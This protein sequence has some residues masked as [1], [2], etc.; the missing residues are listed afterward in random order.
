M[1][2]DNVTFSR[3]LDLSPR[4][5]WPLESDAHPLFGT[6]AKCFSK[7]TQGSC[8]LGCADVV[9]LLDAKFIRTDER[10]LDILTAEGMRVSSVTKALR[11]H[12]DR[13][14]VLSF[15]VENGPIF[16]SYLRFVALPHYCQL[17]LRH[18]AI[19]YIDGDWVDVP[20]PAVNTMWRLPL[21]VVPWLDS[22]YVDGP[23]FARMYQS[24]F[25]WLVDCR[26]RNIDTEGP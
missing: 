14:G 26:T 9:N 11:R 20:K 13:C 23:N 17:I 22:L 6:A 7:A 15:E 5:R 2:G 12:F 18:H 8:P 16:P 3:A 19:E 4:L 25:D 24:P 21:V 1:G 10:Y